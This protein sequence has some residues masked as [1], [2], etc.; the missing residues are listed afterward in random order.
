MIPGDIDF[1][2]GVLVARLDTGLMSKVAA[3]LLQTHA[4]SITTDCLNIK[5]ER[6]P[7]QLLGETCI[8]YSA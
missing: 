5:I 7:G 6:K 8:N 2:K 1:P 3:S 4:I